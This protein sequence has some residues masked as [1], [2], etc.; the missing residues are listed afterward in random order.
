MSRKQ[1]LI[2]VLCLAAAF[3]AA[4]SAGTAPSARHEDAA[5]E[6]LWDIDHAAI[7][8]N[9]VTVIN[10]RK[11]EMYS[12]FLSPSSE[13]N[14]TDNLIG[15]YPLPVGG[16]L[17]A[18]LP[19]SADPILWDIRLEDEYHENVEIYEVDLSALAEEG[20]VMELTT[21]DGAD[22]VFTYREFSPE[23]EEKQE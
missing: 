21:E 7:S 19:V 22:K 9:T 3:S 8:T 12:L 11:S 4:C 23:A 20:M 5:A 13:E 16:E 2:P 17:E 10:R 6:P 15:E 1:Y 14:W 18:A